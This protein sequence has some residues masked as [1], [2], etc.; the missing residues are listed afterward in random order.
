MAFLM[1]SRSLG[2]EV[3]SISTRSNNPSN[4]SRMSRARFMLL[5]YIPQDGVPLRDL[6]Q[7]VYSS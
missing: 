2:F 4:W 3:G 1:P 5:T 7:T 6:F